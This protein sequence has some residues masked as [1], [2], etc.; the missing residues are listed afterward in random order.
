MKGNIKLKQVNKG[1]KL[2]WVESAK[3]RQ[4]L[5]ENAQ[6]N[7]APKNLHKGP[8]YRRLSYCQFRGMRSSA[9]MYAIDRRW[10]NRSLITASDTPWR[11]AENDD[12]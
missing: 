10:C 3:Q 7:V 5:L 1:D 2:K 11:K 4:K 6:E 12:G 8:I 9:G